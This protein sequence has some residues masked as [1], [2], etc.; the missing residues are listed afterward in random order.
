[1]PLTIILQGKRHEV[2]H[3]DGDTI[4]DAARRAGLKPPT[5]C[6]AGNCA[7]CMAIVQDGTATMRYNN[8]LDAD[9][10]DDGWVLTCQAVPDGDVTVEY[11]DY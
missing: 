6:E 1:M 9:E 3:V 8:A 5:S 4:V 7:T 2:D 10:V 11:E